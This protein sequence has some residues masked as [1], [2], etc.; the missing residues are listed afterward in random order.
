MGVFY[1]DS[2]FVVVDTT[3]FVNSN[4]SSA[5]IIIRAIQLSLNLFFRQHRRYGNTR[6]IMIK[7]C[8]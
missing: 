2:S 3:K 7:S 6:T 5:R 1:N 4:T 8:I